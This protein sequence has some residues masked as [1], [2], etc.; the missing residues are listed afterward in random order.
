M[1]E[2]QE[3]PLH[4]LWL[5]LLLSVGYYWFE[6]FD[7]IACPFNTVA[8]WGLRLETYAVK[9]DMIFKGEYGKPHP[10]RYSREE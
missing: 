9:Q 5:R 4:S 3:E 1:P 6:C 2:A 10:D 7:W 8:Y